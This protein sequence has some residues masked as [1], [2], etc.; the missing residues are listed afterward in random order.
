MK[1]T[2]IRPSDRAHWND[3]PPSGPVGAIA[4]ALY[5]HRIGPELRLWE[6]E[7]RAAF[8]ARRLKRERLQKAQHDGQLR[9]VASRLAAKAM[10]LAQVNQ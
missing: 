4:L 10:A 6:A 7:E 1:A 5:T 8:E 2:R 9:A 3:P